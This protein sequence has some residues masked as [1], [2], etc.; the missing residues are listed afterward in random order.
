[1]CIEP[2][3]VPPATSADARGSFRLTAHYVGAI[4]NNGPPD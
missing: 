4:G 3:Q 2:L 1:M